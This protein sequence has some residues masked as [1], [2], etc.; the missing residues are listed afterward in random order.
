MSNKKTSTVLVRERMAK[1]RELME[2]IKK[3]LEV[4]ATTVTKTVDMISALKDVN[5][6]LSVRIGALEEKL[7][8]SPS[9]QT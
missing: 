6:R 5:I 9:N 7:E 2:E 3:N 4:M 8:D 1:D